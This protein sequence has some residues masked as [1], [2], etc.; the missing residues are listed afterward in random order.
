MSNFWNLII[1]NLRNKRGDTLYV[2]YPCFDGLISGVLAWEFLETQHWTIR[3]V[4]PINYNVRDEWLSMSLGPRT[5]VVDFLYHPKS[6]YFG[7]IITSRVLS[8][9]AQGAISSTA[10]FLP[11]LYDSHSGSTA[12]LLWNRFAGALELSRS[13]SGDG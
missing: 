7:Q 6:P 1:R 2:H 9:V 8:V 12:L 10:R 13:L 3:D 5:A 11:L 4:R